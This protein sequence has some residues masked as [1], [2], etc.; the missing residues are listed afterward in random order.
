VRKW[1]PWVKAG[2]HE[3]TNAMGFYSR[4]KLDYPVSLGGYRFAKSP[5]EPIGLHLVHV[6]APAGAGDQR[7]V[8]RAGRA[9]LHE[10]PFAQFEA[11]AVDELT[12][13]LGPYGFAPTRDIEAISVYRW[14]HG[15]AYGFNTLYD[16]EQEPEAHVTARQRIGRIAIANS[17]AGASA[18]AHVAIDQALRA[19][20]EL[21]S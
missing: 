12:R 5:E 6:P 3:V 20:D 19:V 8:W 7:A 10:I 4:I 17:D 15:Y 18:Y 21:E 11:H 2:V 1:T 9:Q 16:E 14:A 13:I